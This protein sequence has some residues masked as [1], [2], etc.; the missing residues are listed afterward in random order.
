LKFSSFKAATIIEMRARDLQYNPPLNL[1]HSVTPVPA[2][3]DGSDL[4]S[5]VFLAEEPPQ[6]AQEINDRVI[7]HVS[8]NEQ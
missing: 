6:L 8:S 3:G 4:D 5:D 1:S 7:S 2:R